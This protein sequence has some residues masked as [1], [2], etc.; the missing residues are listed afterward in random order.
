[1]KTIKLNRALSWDKAKNGKLFTVVKSGDVQVGDKFHCE[2]TTPERKRGFRT[3]PAQEFNEVYNVVGLG[4][5][6]DCEIYGE[7]TQRAY[8]EKV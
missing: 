5:V 6:Y 2:Y 3:L 7:N 1:M 4:K 8:I